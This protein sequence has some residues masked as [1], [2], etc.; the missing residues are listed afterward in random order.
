MKAISGYA[1]WFWLMAKGWKDV[2][3]RN[4][5]MTR[6]I[7]RDKLPVRIWLH[8][9]K[10]KT[11]RRELD[12]I[13]SRLSIEQE[14]EFAQVDWSKYRG[15]LIGQVTLVDEITHSDI[16]VKHLYSPWF[17]GDY[18]FIVKDGMLLNNPIPY[19]GQLGFFEI[20][21]PD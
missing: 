3:N 11:P 6:Y 5:S 4:W 8:A 19:R 2:E 14:N 18:G 21:L 1:E 16:G 7:R 20:E 17:F 10:T 9:S 13:L 12:Y 15:H